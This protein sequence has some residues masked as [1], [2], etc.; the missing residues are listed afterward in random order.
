VLA[1]LARLPDA[2][3]TKLIVDWVAIR[4]ETGGELATRRGSMRGAVRSWRKKMIG[5]RGRKRGY[6]HLPGSWGSC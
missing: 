4:I 3:I 2:P 1:S 6:L 5:L